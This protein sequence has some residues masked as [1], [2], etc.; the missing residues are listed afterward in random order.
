MPCN[1]K[2]S[3]RGGQGSPHG[4]QLRHLTRSHLVE[5]TQLGK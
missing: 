4:A 5:S 2:G 1:G 3:C